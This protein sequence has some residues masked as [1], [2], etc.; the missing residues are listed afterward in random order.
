MPFHKSFRLQNKTFGSVE[1]LLSFSE[2]INS[3]VASFLK[4]WFH[5]N[6]CVTVQTSGSTG[7]PKSIQLKKAFMLNSAKAT[8]SYFHLP[9]NTT[10]LLCLSP[11]Y[12]AGKMMLVRSLVLGWDLTV[13]NP[14]ANPLQNKPKT[15]DF[16]AMVPLQVH[17]SL[18]DLYKVKK[19]IVGGGTISSELLSEIESVK[20]KIFATYGMTETCTHVAVKKLNYFNKDEKE[21]PYYQLIPE[22]KIAQDARGCLVI[23][24]PKLSEEKIVTNDMVKLISNTEFEW[25]GRFDN[26]INSGG[27]KLMPEQ[28][29]KKLATVIKNQ[30]FFVAG[31]PDAVLGEKLILLVEGVKNNDLLNDVK[32]LRILSKYETP[33]AVFYLQ[34]FKE[35][36]TQKMDRLSTLVAALKNEI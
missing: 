21:N 15:Y 2:G 31:I 22:V 28:I 24:A 32:N 14:V 30:R 16:A 3:D 29:E 27:I 12:I 36:P 34:K 26:V 20:S 1:E 7:K 6:L 23:D 18:N 5:A 4:E 13:V 19:L 25:L 35:T 17:H 9:Q 11:N 10:A 8:G 33:K